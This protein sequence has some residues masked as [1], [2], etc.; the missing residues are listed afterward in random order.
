MDFI[1][2]R[3]DEKRVKPL[4]W[5]TLQNPDNRRSYRFEALVDS[6]SDSCFFDAEI[7]EALGIDIS[8]GDAGEVRGVV[9]GK[10]VRQYAH[11]VI[12]KFGEKSFAIRAGFVHGLSRH[13]YGIL[14][15]NGFFDQ[16]KLVSFQKQK[17]IFSVEL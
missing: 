4:V 12:L 8:T 5:I 9:P 3:F 10:W 15:Q 6:G 17:G 16:V 14:G 13:G 11:P 2:K 7:G 1:Y